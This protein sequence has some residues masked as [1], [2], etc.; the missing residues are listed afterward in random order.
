L[1]IRRTPIAR[2][3]A[4]HLQSAD[5]LRGRITATRAC[6]SI[7]SMTQRHKLN[8]GSEAE[9]AEQLAFDIIFYNSNIS[10]GS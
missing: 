4:R 8:G 5:C 10:E 9:Q 1:S 7:S 3:G 2:Y 6:S